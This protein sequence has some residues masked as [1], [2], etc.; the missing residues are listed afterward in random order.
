MN[1]KVAVLAIDVQNDFM[2]ITSAA[3]P[4]T[5][6]VKDTERIADLIKKVNPQTIFASQDSH[7]TLDI[8]HTGWWK[9][10]QGNNLPPFTMITSAD[11]ENGKYIPV[12]DPKR[13]LDYIKK[14]EANGEYV[15]ILWPDHC[16][17]GTEGHAF[18]PTFFAAIQ[19]WMHKNKRWANFIVKGVNPYTEHFGIFRANVPLQEDPNTQVNQGIFATLNSHDTIYLV[20]QARSHCVANSLKQMLSIAPQL[21]SKLV[22]L[23]DCMSNVAGLPTDFYNMVDTIYSDAKAQGVQITTSTNV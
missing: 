2:D 15:H 10:A 16:L 22:V 14:L 17:M 9:D 21:A 6:A 4:V 5:G 23:E 20:G 8:A 19:E 18:H 7:Y 3:L 1:N 13:S 11:I 12:I